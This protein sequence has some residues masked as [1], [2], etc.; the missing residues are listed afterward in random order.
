MK[1]ALAWI[2]VIAFN[3][4]AMYLKLFTFVKIWALIAVPLGAPQIGLLHAYGACLLF[5]HFSGDS[6]LDN[7]KKND[8]DDAIDKAVRRFTFSIVG[9]LV[10][11]GLA[12]L[13]F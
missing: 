9:S 12:Y 6:H 5:A 3:I 11:W 4:G 2:G 1:T 13:L 10:S 8:D 7:V